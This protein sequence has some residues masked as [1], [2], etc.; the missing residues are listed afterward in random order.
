MMR[1]FGVKARLVEFLGILDIIFSIISR[2]KGGTFSVDL[3]LYTLRHRAWTFKD[4][5]DH[6]IEETL[7]HLKQ[8]HCHTDSTIIVAA[9]RLT[10]TVEIRYGMCQQTID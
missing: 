6:P 8:V 2:L 7:E 5:D 3:R 4:S 9:Y 1:L 10:L